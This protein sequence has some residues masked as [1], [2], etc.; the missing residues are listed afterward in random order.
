MHI[1]LLLFAFLKVHS[2]SSIEGECD[3]DNSKLLSY[4]VTGI[5][6]SCKETK[7]DS[8]DVK[9]ANK[10]K[11]LM[12]KEAKIQVRKKMEISLKRK[13]IRILLL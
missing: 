13:K 5:S 11:R 4:D 7:N 10:L 9:G 3:K 6:G 12:E 2:G 1:L 8:I